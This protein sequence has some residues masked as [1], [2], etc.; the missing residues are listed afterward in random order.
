MP[1]AESPVT[2]NGSFGEGGGALLRTALC[3]SAL[4]QKPLHIHSI[5]GAT[6]KPGLSPEDFGVL[7]T[8]IKCT[9]AQ[10]EN[11]EIG[12]EALEFTPKTLP[13]RIHFAHDI[14]RSG[15]GRSPGNTLVI[16]QT[17]API[18]ARTGAISSLTLHGETHNNNTLTFDAFELSTQPAHAAQGI[19]LFSSIHQAGFGYAGRGQIHI[20]IE[21]SALDPIHWPRRGSVISA[22]ARITACDVPSQLVS[23]A[24]SASIKLLTE[25]GF[26]DQVDQIELAGPEPGLSITFWIKFE[27][28]FGSASACWH[29]GGKAT[30]T[31]SRAWEQ[32][33][34][35]TDT[36]ATV[37]PFL[38]DQLL[39]PACL[40]EGPSTFTTSNITRRFKTMAWV[41]K[42]FTPIAITIKGTE[43]S[44]GTITISK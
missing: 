3:M 16:A 43:G 19:G 17:V 24:V 18:L 35:F 5:R 39:L 40:A 1:T 22:G 34:H 23:D 14:P 27:H 4:T 28:G 6:R 33:T 25:A 15:T 10:T 44:P 41:I 26:G 7:Q 21:P 37:D 12:T 32:F 42:Q 38:A 29:R 36:T 9:N 20:E 13:R 8:L 30:E 11:A 31:V 2:L